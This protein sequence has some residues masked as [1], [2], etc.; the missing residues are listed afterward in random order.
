MA[1]C[2]AFLGLS[3][4]RSRVDLSGRSGL[5][6]LGGGVGRGSVLTEDTRLDSRVDLLGALVL[7][8]LGSSSG[9]DG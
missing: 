9:E 7:G 5:L 4:S 2:L 3:W 8:G 6:G 1:T